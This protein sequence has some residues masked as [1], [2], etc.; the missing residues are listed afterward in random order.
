MKKIDG[1][2]FDLDG[3][4]L[5]S[6]HI[7]NNFA[8]KYLIKNGAIPTKELG[9]KVKV[10]SL[11]QS[12]CY[13]IDEYG[14]NKSV[15]EIMEEVNDMTEHFYTDEVLPKKGVIEFLESLKSSG[16]KMCIA[17]ATDKHLVTAALERNNMLH[18]FDEIFTC[19][20]VGHGKDEPHIYNAAL[21]FL[22][23]EK[24]NTWVFEDALYAAATAKKAGFNVA[25]VFDKYESEQT[26]LKKTADIYIKSYDELI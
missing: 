26:E 11:Y 12:A 21:D 18:Y 14:L 5:D 3:T 10:M 4:L 8:E 16:T 9:E 6:M 2:I 1:A 15:E 19:T 24:Q 25:A 17:T 23:T 20:L 13:F 22:K 7:W